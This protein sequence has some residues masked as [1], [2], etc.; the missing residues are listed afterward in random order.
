V[1]KDCEAAELSTNLT[2][3]RPIEPFLLDPGEIEALC[4]AELRPLLRAVLALRA[5]KTASVYGYFGDHARARE[6][7]SRFVKLSDWKLP[8]FFT[9]LLSCTPAARWIGAVTRL[10]R[11]NLRDAHAQ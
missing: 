7:M 4:P 1:R 11:L 10:A 9:A 5:C 6:L 3:V 8:W 2:G